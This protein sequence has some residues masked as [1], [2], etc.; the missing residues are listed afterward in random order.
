MP[1]EQQELQLKVTLDD[2]AT[3]QL[4]R[5]RQ[6][7]GAIGAAGGGSS[8]AGHAVRGVGDFDKAL[9]NLTR[10]LLGVGR[11]TVDFAKIIG[12]MPVAFGT[13]AYQA[14]RAS[15]ATD[16]WATQMV[17][18][19]NAA[20]MMGAALGDYGASLEALEGVGVGAPAAT[21]ALAELSQAVGELSRPGSARQRAL[22]Q[23]AGAPY[24]NNMARSI[25]TF[26]S[27][28]TNIERLNFG[29]E[30]AANLER[31]EMQR[32]GSAA[33]AA[34]VRNRALQGFGLSAA[35]YLDENAKAFSKERQANMKTEDAAARAL[36]AERQTEKQDRERIMQILRASTSGL[37]LAA[38]KAEVAVLEAILNRLEKYEADRIRREEE[39]K[40]NKTSL[41]LPNMSLRNLLPSLKNALG[42]MALEGS[43][44]SALTGL[45]AFGGGQEAVQKTDD[46][47]KELSR[48]T[49][50]LQ[51]ILTN[52]NA[53]LLGSTGVVTPYQ[54]GGTTDIATAAVIAEAGE[55]ETVVNSSGVRTYDR[56]TVG[57]LKPGDT[58]IPTFEEQYTKRLIG[59]G[60]GPTDVKNYLNT[61]GIMMNE[62]D[63]AK[64]MTTLVATRGGA[65]P[66]EDSRYAAS[67]WNKV[68]GAQEGYSNDPYAINWSVWQR[69]GVNPGQPGEHITEP[70][71]QTDAQGN[72]TGKFINRGVNQAAPDIARQ[73]LTE[74]DPKNV[75]FKQYHEYPL[76]MQSLVATPEMTGM[77]TGYKN[78][79]FDTPDVASRI[80]MP[81]TSLA[82]QS[83]R[84]PPA[85][86]T[87][88]AAVPTS[89][90]IV[91]GGG[92][93]GGAGATG[94]V[95]GAPQQ[96]E[97]GPVPRRWRTADWGAA[98]RKL[99]GALVS[100]IWLHGREDLAQ[101]VSGPSGV[102]G[103]LGSA[104]QNIAQ[105]TLSSTFGDLFQA[106][107]QLTPQE[108]ARRAALP[109]VPME[110]RV[111]GSQLDK[112][113][114]NELRIGTSGKID[115]EHENPPPGTTIEKEGKVLEGGETTTTS[116]PLFQMPSTYREPESHS[117]SPVYNAARAVSGAARRA[118]PN[119]DRPG[120]SEDQASVGGVRG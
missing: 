108:Q 91:G 65:M 82:D 86:Q 104:A 115:I 87:Q 113:M 83:I 80:P 105:G 69:P 111:D 99:P 32:T 61:R 28:K 97:S 46:N 67:S 63:C 38:T 98:A 26:N 118:N 112:P 54:R 9:G 50:N 24:A 4:E 114:G 17:G 21:R 78:P 34:D 31:Q 85:E 12:P 100:E 94:T 8:E 22:M 90:P 2:E 36:Y 84:I 29:R 37:S 41:H 77:G 106:D 74:I 30:I 119:I 73:Q 109:Q 107:R 110:G 18:A 3:A 11:A 95:P 102:V 55:P 49:G 76:G 120:T 101:A 72:F 25:Q 10:S 66:P 45:P 15:T 40:K 79:M 5:I 71:P 58:V 23:L 51:K 52:P 56:P 57:V 53:I 43:G 75:P 47:T 7:L 117:D 16:E 81:D 68:P 6:A 103:A 89:A 33:A 59:A 60:A 62:A 64:Y 1:S 20:R 70:I 27:L 96:F 19:S 42:G 48:L 116:M 88:P 92:S 39:D 44:F 14:Y 35:I 93:S 13:L